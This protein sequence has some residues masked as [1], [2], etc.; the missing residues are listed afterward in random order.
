MVEHRTENP[1]V[2]S[3]ILSLGKNLLGRIL[4]LVIGF[5]LGGTMYEVKIAIKFFLHTHPTVDKTTT[6]GCSA[7]G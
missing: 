1:G 6:S 3:S 4:G 5:G 7:V 2:E